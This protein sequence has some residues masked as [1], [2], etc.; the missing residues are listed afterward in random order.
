MSGRYQARS[1]SDK[2]DDW[3]LWFIADSHKSGL[4]VTTPLARK[5]LNPDWLFPF[6]PK[7]CAILAAKI[8]NKLEKHHV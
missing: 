3:P 8:F 1:A 2:T 5:Y 7:E 6:M 4:N